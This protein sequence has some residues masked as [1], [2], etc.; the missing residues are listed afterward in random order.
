MW[1]SNASAATAAHAVRVAT[2]VVTT[3]VVHAVR[4]VMVRAAKAIAAHVAR[5]A[6]KL[7]LHSKTLSQLKNNKKT[8]ADTASY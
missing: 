2:A 4:V 1:G 8:T 3:T 7:L 5:V 6:T